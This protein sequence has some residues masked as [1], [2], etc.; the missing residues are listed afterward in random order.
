MEHWPSDERQERAQDQG[1]SK[2]KGKRKATTYNDSYWRWPH[3]EHGAIGRATLISRNGRLQWSTVVDTSRSRTLV[4]LCKPT[5]IFPETRS[6]QVDIGKY[7]L[8]QR[9]EQGLSYLRKYFP[10]ADFPAELVKGELDFEVD[11]DRKLETFDP[12]LGNL[13]EVLPSHFP[14]DGY[15][16]VFPMG[17]SNKELNISPLVPD[18][19]GH[20]IFKPSATPSFTL[21]TPILQLSSP[22]AP[23]GSITSPSVA[24]VVRS[25]TSTSL[26]H[27]V[28]SEGESHPTV[29]K[30]IDITRTDTGDMPVLDSRILAAGPDILLVNR[31]GHVYKCST[32]QGGKA[33]YSIWKTTSDPSKNGLGQLWQLGITD[34][35][36]GCF[37]ASNQG[38]KYLDFRSNTAADVFS[39]DHLGA[40]VT[41]FE[42]SNQDH[43]SRISTT[44]DVVWLDDR[45][46]RKPLISIK[47]HR[48]FDRTLGLATAQLDSG[49]LSLLMSRRNGFVTVYDVSRA[50]D[51]LVHCNSTPACLV[52]DDPIQ[53]S[54]T[55][56]A[57]VALPCG[58]EL[59]LLRLGQRGNIY[60]QDIRARMSDGE[61]TQSRETDYPTHVWSSDVQELDRQA[62]AVQC[63]YGPVGAKHYTEVNLRSAY[64]KIFTISDDDKED[65]TKNFHDMVEHL[66]GIWHR[67]E[68]P[69]ENML[70]S[71]DVISR[72]CKERKLPS[73]A[74]FLA[75]ASTINSKGYIR[76]LLADSFPFHDLANAAAWH[77]S[78]Q[79]TSSILSQCGSDD[80]PALHERLKGMDLVSDTEKHPFSLQR[81]T[82]ARE[83]LVV[84]LALSGDVYSGRPLTKPHPLTTNDSM[85]QRTKEPPEVHF[86]YFH[87]I[88][89]I[90]AHHYADVGETEEL[91]EA[92]P[93]S[94]SQ[95]VRLLLAEWEVGTDPE[96][97]IYRDPYNVADPDELPA[98]RKRQA[99]PTPPATQ[100]TVVP[101]HCPP[102]VV[103]TRVEHLPPTQ[104]SKRAPTVTQT[105]TV[106]RTLSQTASDHP[107]VFSQE[108]M[109]STQVLPG[110]FGGRPSVGAKKK[111]TLKRIARTKLGIVAGPV[112][113]ARWM[114]LGTVAPNPW[115]DRAALNGAAKRNKSVVCA[116][117]ASYIS[118]F[119]GYPLD[120]LKSRLQTTKTRISVPK[121]AGL[122][123]REE[124]VIGFYRGLWIPLMTISFV[125]AASFT[126][127]S[128]TKEYCRIN[129]YFT[130]NK[131]S[132]AALAGGLSG[133]LSG[134]LISFGSA[135]FE[136][137][138]VRRQLEY[139]IAASK[140]IQLVKPPNTLEAVRDIFRTNGL[141]GLYIG[142]RLHF[143][144]DTAG[145]ALY[146]FE[147][148]ALRHLLGRRRSG[149]QGPTPPWLPIPVSLIPFV[150]GSFAGVTSWALIYPLD[151]VKTKIQQ[152]ALAGTPPRGVWE[153]LRR[154]VRGPDPKDPKPVLAG[155]ARIYRGLGVSAVRSITTH[156]LLWTFFDITSHYIDHLP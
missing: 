30:A 66:A 62:G 36:D 102:M 54:Y 24:F 135:P 150:C 53:K 59:S 143:L 15:N 96:N 88:R 92:A 152:R 55:G 40:V 7:S 17:E 80:W 145:T 90:G 109:A 29:T 3:L 126:I 77:Y 16:I 79:Q 101:S 127:Y 45:F 68:E 123:Y 72:T 125:R 151:V 48:S 12:F 100:K 155:I 83:Q 148:D 139:S 141:R 69:V 27:I 44:D 37:L 19:S 51:G 85:S 106:Q 41:F 146:F 137:V 107:E 131:V 132:D 28:T 47:H 46:R 117:S 114:E 9:S 112:K 76:A 49:P 110:R 34:R 144:R 73:C 81:E 38:V 42:C 97:Y 50:M 71:F 39:N 130:R 89:K 18:A 78:V 74:D 91:D 14:Q 8:R 129:N 142:F 87:P 94:S 61:D 70:T 99:L 58:S 147:Y 108:L 33:M 111:P 22:V 82:E 124:G 119:A 11:E 5:R 149:E 93:F 122:V 13:L 67:A 133:A 134:S 84:D 105:Q 86:G 156:G 10:D 75:G 154:L 63:D 103:A 120:S 113:N 153:T 20:F 121:L 115:F 26:V 35:D 136:L 60:R 1:K 57:V 138:K 25:Y 65:Y 32:G 21:E 104:A 43:L 95:G 116:L 4:S 52:Q 140:G 98:P 64:E 128:D 31:V 56:H 23:C 6:P 118:T 2:D